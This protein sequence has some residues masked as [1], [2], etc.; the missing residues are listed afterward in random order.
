MTLALVCPHHAWESVSTFCLPTA[1]N[2]A[3]PP[4]LLKIH[5]KS[6]A[7]GKAPGTSMLVLE[8]RGGHRA[9]LELQQDYMGLR[10]DPSKLRVLELNHQDLWGGVDRGTEKPC[11]LTPFQKSRLTGCLCLLLSSQRRHS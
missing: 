1:E 9:Q 3:Y 11:E 8:A 7:P 4:R 6:S 10:G 5:E 2:T